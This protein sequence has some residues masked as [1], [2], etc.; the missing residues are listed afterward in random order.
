MNRQCSESFPKNDPKNGPKMDPKMVQN[1]PKLDPKS[2]HTR[3]WTPPPKTG[4][5][6]DLLGALSGR[7]EGAREGFK[8]G[9]IFFFRSWGR[10]GRQKGRSKRGLRRKRS[11]EDVD[12]E[13]ILSKTGVSVPKK[14]PKCSPG[15]PKAPPRPSEL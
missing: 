3:I 2:T 10:L 1:G 6:G 9:S 5:S 7:S 14:L 12:G 11:H 4:P 13:T 8:S 15:R